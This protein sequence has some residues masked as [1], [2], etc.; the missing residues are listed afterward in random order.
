MKCN[1]DKKYVYADGRQLTFTNSEDRERYKQTLDRLTAV[2][3][4][5]KD[6]T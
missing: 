3:G 2:F 4:F 6:R 5:A 1:V